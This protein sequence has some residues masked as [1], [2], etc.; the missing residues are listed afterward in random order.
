[1]VILSHYHW[2]E[3]AFLAVALVFIGAV[4]FPIWLVLRRPTVES[5]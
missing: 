4:S 3:L 2:N 1:M 5:S